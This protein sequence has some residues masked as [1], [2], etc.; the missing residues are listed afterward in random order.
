MLDKQ[1]I[2]DSGKIERLVRR[3][4]VLPKLPEFSPEWLEAQPNVS[5]SSILL[6]SGSRRNLFRPVAYSAVAA[7]FVAI[8]AVVFIYKSKNLQ[9]PGQQNSAEHA[10]RKKTRA[11]RAIVLFV[12]GDVQIIRQNKETEIYKGDTLN[13]GDTIR[14]GA[15]GRVGLA[16]GSGIQVSIAPSSL[17]N[18]EEFS[19]LEKEKLRQVSIELKSGEL[20]SHVDKLRS[21]ENVEVIT[22]T[23]VAGVRGTSFIVKSSEE[24]TQVIMIDGSVA[25]SPK[26]KSILQNII[27]EGPVILEQGQSAVFKKGESIKL[28][29]VS[30]KVIQDA[31]VIIAQVQKEHK[32]VRKVIIDSV[33][34]LNPL[35]NP[36]EFRKIY[37]RDPE[38][39][40]LKN[41]RVLKGVVAS[42]SGEKLVVHS[43]EGAH[44]L[45][46][47]DIQEIRYVE[48]PENE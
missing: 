38:I 16:L 18:L 27:I 31:E 11:L 46:A 36:E 1:Y 17:V 15:V 29:P 26:K 7:L 8:F 42:Q 22:P 21:G 33:S 3:K 39:I 12:E 28:E 14:T 24:S 48:I 2:K 35:K 23:S 43:T 10:D 30:Q 19:Q 25:L 41:G 47:G 4:P 9:L 37:G 40:V 44:I 6:K 13:T 20:I 34:E 32:K 5:V 45:N